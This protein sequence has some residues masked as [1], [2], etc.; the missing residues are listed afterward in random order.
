M[1]A[2][3]PAKRR[4][5]IADDEKLIADTLKLILTQIGYDVAV[6]YDGAAAIEAAKRWS[7]DLLLTDVYMPGHSGV[8]AAIQICSLLP[9]CKVLL[10]TGQPDLQRIRREVLSKCYKFDVFS[11]PVHPKE[12]IERVRDILQ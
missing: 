6:V 4:I 7:P 3:A 12:L 11:K 1:C 5:L 10:F 2:S 8:D 9:R